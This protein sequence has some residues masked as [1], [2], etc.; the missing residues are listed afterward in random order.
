MT[1][2]VLGFVDADTENPLPVVASPEEEVLGVV[3][4][5]EGI[6]PSLLGVADGDG[7]LRGVLDL[8]AGAYKSVDGETEM[9]R[10]RRDGA[11]LVAGADEPAC[12]LV[13]GVAAGGGGGAA[14]EEE[15]VFERDRFL[16]VTALCLAF[17][18]RGLWEGGGEG[19]EES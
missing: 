17:L 19:G 2:A 13:S 12:F 4:A 6:A 14:V 8:D 18:D 15:G 9:F 3:E 1:G 16:R 5:V 10:I 11:V 7:G